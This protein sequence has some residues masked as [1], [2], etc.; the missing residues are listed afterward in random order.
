MKAKLLILFLLF[1]TQLGRTQIIWELPVSVRYDLDQA[2]SYTQNKLKDVLL[3]PSERVKLQSVLSQLYNKK[4]LFSQGAKALMEVQ[5]LEQSSVASRVSYYLAK[6]INHKFKNE[7]DSALR[8]YDKALQWAPKLKDTQRYLQVKIEKAEYFRRFYRYDQAVQL[9]EEIF[10]ELN[11]LQLPAKELRAYALNRKAAIMDETGRVDETLKASRACIALAKEVN[12]YY[13]MAASYNEI[14]FVYKNALE[15]DSSYYYYQLVEENFRKGHMLLDATQAWFNRLELLIHNKHKMPEAIAELKVFVAE[16]EKNEIQFPMRMAFMYL[17][18]YSESI[19][20]YK[21]AALYY[22]KYNEAVSR[23]FQ[24]QFAIQ[25]E[26][27]KQAYENDKIALENKE[28]NQE[29]KRK[30]AEIKRKDARM[31]WALIGLVLV[32]GGLFVSIRMFAKFKKLSKKLQVQN[33]EKDF[34]IQEV[35]HRVKNNLHFIHSLLEMQK[36]AS[37]NIEEAVGLEE[38]SLRISCVSLVHE[39]LFQGGNFDKVNVSSYIQELLQHLETTF[40]QNGK[41]I[42]MDLDL[43]EEIDFSIQNCTALGLLLSELYTNSIKYAFPDVD[44]PVFTVS[45]KRVS[46]FNSYQLEVR[47]NGQK[48]IDFEAQKG[49]KTLGMRLIDIFSRQLKGDYEIGWNKGF[50]YKLIFLADEGESANS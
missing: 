40:M 48:E 41:K 44:N 30:R 17:A 10:V 36:N 15:I 1:L 2:F 32:L 16:Y 27:V 22:K 24:V 28:I 4:G 23:E 21:S 37:S 49:R 3:E 9:I 46:S 38:A 47:D 25:L 29:L 39:F 8:H 43:A 45:F 14:G 18:E 7:P 35:H 11:Q 42:Q 6:A 50:Y 31:L 34:L 19:G 33:E 12:N 20:D 13:L 26:N 5:N